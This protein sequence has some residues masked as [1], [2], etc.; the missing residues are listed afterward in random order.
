M[1]EKK[2]KKWVSIVSFPND[3]Q[4]P[5]FVLLDILNVFFLLFLRVK[6]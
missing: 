1:E 2:R 6:Y 4:I 3:I 5:F